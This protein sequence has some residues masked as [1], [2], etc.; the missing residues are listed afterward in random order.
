[1]FLLKANCFFLQKKKVRENNVYIDIKIQ[2]KNFDIKQK[3]EFFI[4]S[5]KSDRVLSSL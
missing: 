4:S 3:P 5:A 2:I 1:M